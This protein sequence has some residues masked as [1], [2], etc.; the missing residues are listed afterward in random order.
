MFEKILNKSTQL[1]THFTNFIFPAHKRP[2]L[3]A[4]CHLQGKI[5]KPL[6]IKAASLAA[7]LLLL[8]SGLSM[9]GGMA[10]ERIGYRA[11]ASE[12]IRRSLAGP[13]AIAGPVL[14]RR[15][16]ETI[17]KQVTVDK[18]TS[19]ERTEHEYVLKALPETMKWTATSRIEP[20]YRGLY[21][22]NSFNLD[23]SA[24]V[25]WAPPTLAVLTPPAIK[26]P[27]VALTCAAP[28]VE[29]A[30]TDL[31]GIRSVKIQ[32]AG[33]ALQPQASAGSDVF[34]AGFEA[35]LPAG[36]LLAT[37]A[38]TMQLSVEL[39]GVESL[40]FVPLANDN[41]VTLKSDWP[42]PSFS[43]A[44]LPV[45]RTIGNAGFDATWNV[46]SL[47]STAHGQ[48]GRQ[49]ALCDLRSAGYGE[50]N[51]A[52]GVSYA[53]V[54]VQAAGAPAAGGACLQSFGVEFIDPINPASL[55]DRAT[56][57]GLLFI[58]LTFVGIGMLELLKRLPIHPMQYLLIGAAL[59]AF[60]LLLLSLSEHVSFALA[61]AAAATACI[62]LIAVYAKA[63]LGGWARALPTAVALSVLY[64]VLYLVLQSEQHAL[65]AGSLLLFAV[66]AGVML[67]TRHLQ[68]GQLNGKP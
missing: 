6:V 33:E 12:S 43:G 50:Q 55:A 7:I 15:C 9:I 57:Y 1:H 44:F 66:L 8:I 27:A 64:G 17:E 53:E 4:P 46:S 35:T 65:L 41:S 60:F 16:V 32:T 37:T 26:A 25:A 59:A 34:R 20:R 14:T 11:Q 38:L 49:G 28:K 31:R 63:V 23:A 48:L 5:L 52:R 22:V 24:D 62:G 42:H 21:K 68:W 58:A 36:E 18:K 45:A 39:V 61:Y 3:A 56:K 13:Q 2:T 30:V 67:M 29:F 10:A 54:Q 40:S 51:Y 47:A 19:T